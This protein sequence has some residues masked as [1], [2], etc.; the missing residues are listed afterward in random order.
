MWPEIGPFSLAK[1]IFRKAPMQYNK[2]RK[3]FSTNAV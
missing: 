3:V 1:V 2:E